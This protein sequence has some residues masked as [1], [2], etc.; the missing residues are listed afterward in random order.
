MS[1]IRIKSNQLNY[2]VVEHLSK[3]EKVQGSIIGKLTENIHSSLRFA[4][5]CFPKTAKDEFKDSREILLSQAGALKDDDT[6]DELLA[7]IY[8]ERGRSETE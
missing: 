1:N 3:N 8:K 4:T 7:H 2:K 6:L 5:W